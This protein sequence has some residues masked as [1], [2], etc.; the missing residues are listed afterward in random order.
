MTKIEWTEETWNPIIGCSKVSLG[1]DHCY[2]ER[3]ANRLAHIKATA[4]HYGIA[5]KDGRWTGKTLIG[6][7]SALEKPLHW[8]K[9]RT[10]FVCS[11]GD[12]F[13]ESVPYEWV[14]EVWGIMERCTQHTFQVLTKRPEMLVDYLS[15]AL[16]YNHGILP[17][18]W[19]GVTAE[20]QEQADKRIPILL[21]IPAAKRFVS[22]E[23]MLGPVDLSQINI[24]IDRTI[25]HNVLTG[26]PYDWDYGEEIPENR[27]DGLD[28][29]ICGGE[30]GPRARPM[31][32]GWAI[33]LRDQCVEAGVPFFFKQWGEWVDEFHPAVI[34][35]KHE[36]SDQFVKLDD[37]L[38]DY[39]GV[40]M[41]RV[42]KKKAGHLLDSKEW[43]ERP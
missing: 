33:S 25:T 30:S 4:P 5:V 27:I 7:E 41:Y 1:C 32:P 6:A 40:Y 23:P 39:R 42:G 20:N 13:H 12:L 31:H 16:I 38:M 9:P 17:N 37:D 18:V 2:A 26:I 10:I 8:K 21:Q 29:V 19:L 43:R 3:M 35:G 22:I 28:W 24:S 14:N 11:M 36:I 34:H 15:N